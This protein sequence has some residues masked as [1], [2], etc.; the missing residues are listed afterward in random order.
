MIS[1]S[2]I[3]VCN[4]QIGDIQYNINQ[5]NLVNESISSF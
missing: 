5:D 1:D 2:S 4:D 3:T